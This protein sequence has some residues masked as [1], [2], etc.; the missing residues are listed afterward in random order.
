MDVTSHLQAA[1]AALSP[2]KDDLLTIRQKAGRFRDVSL[3]IFEPST[4]T[5]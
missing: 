3:Q 2:E 4:G 5:D 1:P